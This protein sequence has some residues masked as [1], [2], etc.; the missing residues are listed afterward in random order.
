MMQPL[1]KELALLYKFKHILTYDLVIPSLSIYPRG[2]NVYFY[3]KA[4]IQMFIVDLFIIAKK[5]NT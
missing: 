5:Q 4:C 2:M 3:T 1:W